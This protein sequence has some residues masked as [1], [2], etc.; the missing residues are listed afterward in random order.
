[1]EHVDE[2]DLEWKVYSAMYSCSGYFANSQLA[3]N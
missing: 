1:M 3:L 2:N